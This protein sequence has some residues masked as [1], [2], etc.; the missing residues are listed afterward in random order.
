MI[1]YIDTNRK[2]S[3]LL[4]ALVFVYCASCISPTLGARLNTLLSLVL[5]GGV[6]LAVFI[7]DAQRKSFV[8]SSP[9]F[10]PVLLISIIILLYKA[11]GISSA[12]LGNQYHQLAFFSFT[13]IGLFVYYYFPVKQKILLFLSLSA[14]LVA[15]LVNNIF[16]Y[17]AFSRMYGVDMDAVARLME[18][19]VT[20]G[21]TPFNT[22]SIF[23]FAAF[24]FIFLNVKR[25][26][27][28]I[29]A[30]GCALVAMYYM[31]FCGARGTVILL[32]LFLI[33]MLPLLKFQEKS[34]TGKFLSYIVYAFFGLALIIGL[35]SI[36]DFMIAISPDRLAARFIDIK[37]T[38]Q[39]GVS[40]SSFSGRFGLYRVS[41]NTFFGSIISFLF[42]IG[43]HRGSITGDLSYA[44]MGIGGHSEM[45]DN[46]ARFGILGACF[47]FPIYKYAYRWFVDFFES[48]LLKKQLQYIFIVFLICSFIKAVFMPTV[49]CVVFVLLPLAFDFVRYVNNN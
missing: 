34:S 17:S 36:L 40:D 18:D 27:I 45:L 46:L 5:L 41:L 11:L 15:D 39:E 23:A 6:L 38:S 22:T 31:F 37:Q 26:K 33:I 7:T 47:V 1:S 32:D 21:G 12:A 14:V 10:A 44:D 49:G 28:R 13:F 2:V 35:E 48:K 9:L 25:M 29:L 3:Y 8:K 20:I 24:Y 30:L 4:F 16:L 43:D 19:E 42:G